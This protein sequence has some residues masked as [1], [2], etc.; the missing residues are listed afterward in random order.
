MKSRRYFLKQGALATTAVLV[1]NPLLSFGETGSSFFSE[2]GSG[3]LVLLH[4]ND[5]HNHL[6]PVNYNAYKGLG[7]FKKTA[8]VI[9]DLKETH[10]N[11]LLLDAGDI[12]CG[13][14]HHQQEQETTLQLMRSVGYDAVLLGNRD[15]ETGMDYLQ[16]R[17]KKASIPLVTSNYSYKAGWLKN[18]HQPYK[19]VRKGNVRIGIVGAGIDINGYPGQNSY[20]DYNDPV[21]KVSAIAT[22]L[23]KTE[24]CQ[25]VVCLSHLGYKN[26][27]GIDDTALAMQ[28]QN[29][30]VI[31]G[32]H[33]HTFMQTPQIL[34]NRQQQEVIIN[35]AGYGGIALGKMNISFDEKGN[36]N[37]IIFENLMIG[38]DDH[39]WMQPNRVPVLD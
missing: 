4:T 34:L 16:E 13:D 30:D 38:R 5:L 8:G 39:K 35:H 7:G 10:S 14:P 26:K 3:D 12:L 24:H 9:A 29:I 25:L 22:M 21:K 32:G 36:K 15:Y 2:G 19:I 18:W 20:V 28:S 17:W 31:L 1:A 23:K 37:S 27:K 6:T 11:V 33:S